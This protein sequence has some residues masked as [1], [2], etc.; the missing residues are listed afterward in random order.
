MSTQTPDATSPFTLSEWQPE[1]RAR[2]ETD[3]D[4]GTN[5]CSRTSSLIRRPGT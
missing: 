3:A 2:D 5:D 4:R 1:P